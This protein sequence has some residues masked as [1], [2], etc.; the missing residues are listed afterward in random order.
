MR[1]R[2][3]ITAVGGD[4]GSSVIRCLSQEFPKEVLLGC[5]ITPYAAGREWAGEFF[6][7]PPYVQ[8]EKYMDMLLCECRKRGIT[9][10]LPMTEG[11][12][13]VYDKHREMFGAEGMK[14]MIQA[15]DILEMAFSK[16][17]TSK[18]VRKMGLNSPATY[19]ADR[20]DMDLVYPLVIKP[21]R[22]CGSRNVIVVN[23]QKE[24]ETAIE[25]VGDAV[26]QEYVG[27]PEHEFTVGVFSNGKDIKSIAFK[28]TLGF[29]GMS[30]MVQLVEDKEIAKIAEIVAHSLHLRGSINIQMR[31]HKGVY[32]IFEI[33]PRISSTV[34]FRYQLGF[35]DVKWWLDF[36]DGR[37]EEICYIPE[38]LPVVGIRTLGEKI[39]RGNPEMSDE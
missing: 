12:I 15:S 27:D 7:V 5:D 33:N 35:K 30:R 39:F 28:R 4:I 18:A 22:G 20:K 29:G 1:A 13:S 8:E 10:I 14:V 38:S 34:G 25:Q 21:D 36:L 26:L 19:R 17:E 23:N 31:K 3:L 6:C 32:Y 2:Y 11:E 37:E 16:Y 9:H 24:Y